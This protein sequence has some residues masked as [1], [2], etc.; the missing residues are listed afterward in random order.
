MTQEV[1]VVV[2]SDLLMTSLGWL[3]VLNR[4]Y[5]GFFHQLPVIGHG[6]GVMVIWTHERSD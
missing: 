5:V 1:E 3:E 2:S 6:P 4:S